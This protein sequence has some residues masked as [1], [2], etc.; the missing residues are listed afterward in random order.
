GPGLHFRLPWPIESHRIIA[1]GLVRRMDFGLPSKLSREAAT[2]AQ[3]S[4]RPA[5]GSSPAPEQANRVLFQKEAAPEDSALVTG[6]S[7][8]IDLRSAVQFRINSALAYAY[9]LAEPEALVRSTIL[10][11]LRSAVAT[12]EIDAVYTT[13]REEIERSTVE[14]AQAMLDRY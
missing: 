14:A 7:N 12:R 2:R 5:F 6:D 11:A 1:T 4:G 13:A 8:L 9:D 10:S 3:L